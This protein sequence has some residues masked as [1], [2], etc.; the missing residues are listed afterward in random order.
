MIE[1][2]VEVQFAFVLIDVVMRYRDPSRKEDLSAKL[3]VQYIKCMATD[4][5]GIG[6]S[7]H[8]MITAKSLLRDQ[9]T[10]DDTVIK[11]ICWR[12]LYVCTVLISLYSGSWK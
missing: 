2:S 4:L 11:R 10:R 6:Y 8:I 5:L 3:Q 7:T 1:Y 9:N 12:W